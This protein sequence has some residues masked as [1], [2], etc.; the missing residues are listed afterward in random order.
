MLG[1]RKKAGDDPAFVQFVRGSGGAALVAAVR[2]GL[3]EPGG[4][5][6]TGDG[7]AVVERGGAG[8][9]RNGGRQAQSGKSGK[10]QVLH[11]NSPSVVGRNARRQVDM[12][13]AELG[14]SETFHT[15]RALVHSTDEGRDGPQTQS[16][17]R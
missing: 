13:E 16:T 11:R 12:T 9:R 7:A 17:M 15:S 8:K 5:R 6:V 10:D 3:L 1:A 2:A 4:V 14:C